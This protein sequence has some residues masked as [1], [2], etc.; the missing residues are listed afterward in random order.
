VVNIGCGEILQ[1]YKVSVTMQTQYFANASGINT[2]LLPNNP[3]SDQVLLDA[4]YTDPYY[5]L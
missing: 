5:G 3:I 4:I 1:N 2:Y